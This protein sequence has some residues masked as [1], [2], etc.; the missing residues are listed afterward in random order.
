MKGNLKKLHKKIRG[1]I[2]TLPL[3]AR[4]NVNYKPPYCQN[5]Y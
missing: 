3:L 2:I 1:V 5:N 4:H